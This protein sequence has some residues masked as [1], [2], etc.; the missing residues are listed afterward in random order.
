MLIYAYL[1]LVALILKIRNIS[2]ISEIFGLEF[3]MIRLKL[4][5]LSF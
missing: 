3:Y 4:R 2:E 1:Y 5:R